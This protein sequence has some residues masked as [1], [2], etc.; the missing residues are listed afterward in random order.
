VSHVFDSGLADS[1][2][3]LIANAMIAKLAPLKILALGGSTAGFLEQVLTIPFTI[4]G[5]HDE[6]GIDLM[7]QELAG[8][9]PAVAIAPAGMT[10][11]QA[12]GPGRSR[13]EL[14]IDV[15]VISTH[16]RDVTEGRATSD[17]IAA[18]DDSAD[19]GI[20]ATLELVWALLFDLDLGVGSHVQ[21][22]KLHSEDELITDEEKTIWVQKWKVTVTRDA[23][24]YRGM[25]QKLTEL[26]TTM[27]QSGLDP[28]PIPVIED[29]TVG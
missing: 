16:G 21:Q 22:L 10:L 23:N 19:P 28:D 9:S 29:T 8:K 27:R 3:T 4:D 5:K 14:A 2:R 18:A 1:Q 11:T 24:M 12:G 25:I 15:Y 6:Y 20:F 17:A 26:H 13:G 7:W